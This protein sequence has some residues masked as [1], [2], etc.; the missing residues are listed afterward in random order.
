LTQIKNRNIYSLELA[1]HFDPER[2]YDNEMTYEQMAKDIYTFATSLNLNKF[3]LMGLCMGGRVAIQFATM[4]PDMVDG[5]IILEAGIGS[6][7]YKIIDYMLNV[8]ADIISK[9]N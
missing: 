8:I 1:N 6:F 2:F 9:E 5:L 3:T 7:K 4:Y